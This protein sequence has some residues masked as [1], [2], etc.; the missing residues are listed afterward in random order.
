MYCFV[1]DEPAL[2]Q[3][4]G[5]ELGEAVGL[6]YNDDQPANSAANLAG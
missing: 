2:V 5:E 1:G 6:T 3:D 4:A